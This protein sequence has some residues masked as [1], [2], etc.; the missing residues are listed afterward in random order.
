M[1]KG[2]IGELALALEDVSAVGVERPYTAMLVDLGVDGDPSM[3]ST[4]A[5]S[6]GAVLD[7]SGAFSCGP[8]RTCGVATLTAIEPNATAGEA[9]VRLFF[10]KGMWE[11]YMNRR[12]VQTHVY[13]GGDELYDGSLDFCHENL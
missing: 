12:L 11:L 7:R 8:N 6:D 5:R 13:G 10:R 2:K 3:A 9:T 1:L 4:V